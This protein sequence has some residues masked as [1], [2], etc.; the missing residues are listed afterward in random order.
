MSSAESQRPQQP[1]PSPSPRQPARRRAKAS[2]RPGRWQ[3]AEQVVRQASVMNPLRPAVWSLFGGVCLLGIA[4]LFHPQL[5]KRLPSLP[6]AATDAALTPEGVA[7]AAHLP[8]SRGNE[9]PADAVGARLADG[10]RESRNPRG[11]IGPLAALPGSGGVPYDFRGGSAAELQR[12]PLENGSDAR[13]ASRAVGDLPPYPA[14]DPFPAAEPF[15]APNAFPSPTATAT[16]LAELA[17][18]VAELRRHLAELLGAV[19]DLRRD[20]DALA[21][22]PG[23]LAGQDTESTELAIVFDESGRLSVRL[24]NVPLE[25]ALLRLA[26]VAGRSIILPTDPAMTRRV[27]GDLVGDSAEAAIEQLLVRHG[28][29]VDAADPGTPEAVRP[30]IPTLAPPRGSD[31]PENRM[32]PPP[33]IS[34]QPGDAVATGPLPLPEA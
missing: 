21:L 27:T 16:P 24:R 1:Q 14:N 30:K 28:F 17:D 26:G 31:S 22:R 6:V 11:S 32:V 8:G 15:P 4:G 25:T 29:A 3:A 20:V 33:R 23:P 2:Y 5:Q 19:D 10:D 12:R 9:H 18:P 34:E 13:M 7:L